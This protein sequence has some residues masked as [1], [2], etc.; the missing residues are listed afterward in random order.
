MKRPEVAK[1]K[2]LASE[3]NCIPLPQIPDTKQILLPPQEHS[4]IRNNF[5]IYTED[6]LRQL[7]LNY[8]NYEG[9]NEK[10]EKISEK[11]SQINEVPEDQSKSKGLKRDDEVSRPVQTVLRRKKTREVKISL[12][13]GKDR[14][15][16][17]AS[18]DFVENI[19]NT[20]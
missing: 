19:I 12:E 11:A 14:K 9:L 10:N 6:L 16:E 1:M 4:L 17:I 13:L 8:S 15:K 20:K 2:E 3:V 18:D 7:N 5:Q